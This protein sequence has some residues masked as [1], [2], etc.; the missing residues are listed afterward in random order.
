MDLGF[1][2]AGFSHAAL[3]EH[4]ALFCATLRYNRPNWPVL[5]PPGFAGDVSDPLAL[6]KILRQEFQL[7]KPFPGVMVGGPPCQP[8]SIAANQRFSKAGS[9]FKRVGFEHAKN[10]NLLFDMIH[11]V[12]EFMPAA[13]LIENVE[14]LY[15]VDGGEQLQM[16]LNQLMRLG[17]TVAQPA[18]LD[19]A[20]FG[21]PQHRRRLF[22]CGSRLAGVFKPPR[23]SFEPVT[24]ISVL[25]GDLSSL[26]NHEP[27]KHLPQ[28]LL[29]YAELDYGQRDK[30]G[31][32][33]RLHPHKPSKTVIAGGTN[34]GGRSHLHPNVPRTLTARE[35][36]RL[37][38]FPDDYVFLGP[39]ARQFTQVGNA[40]PPILGAQLAAS[41]FD[42][43][44]A[45][46]DR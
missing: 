20:H 19:A 22:V 28:S 15:D 5:G 36:A 23:P 4:S 17:Y 25:G 33:D 7:K 11:L 26:P 45:V 27:R 2:A 6:V 1:E 34:G 14:G 29:R 18:V 3:V 46:S 37:Q 43:F 21:V 40:V 10:G 44:F 41:I 16:A 31:R 35:C 32:V 30:L 39:T 8:F 24:S 13:F 12:G 38:T 42:S 9:N